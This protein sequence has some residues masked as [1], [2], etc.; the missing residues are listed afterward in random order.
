MVNSKDTKKS[1]EDRPQESELTR[2]FSP[3]YLLTYFNIPTDKA[4]AF[5][6]FVEAKEMDTSL[7]DIGKEL[8]LIEHLLSESELFLMI[9]GDK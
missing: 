2:R 5:I 8:Q 6:G 4:E 3:H 1:D 7:L 9:Q